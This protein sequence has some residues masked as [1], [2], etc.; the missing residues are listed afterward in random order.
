MFVGM[1][2]LVASAPQMKDPGKTF[3]R[4][5]FLSTVVL[6][7]VYC[8]VAYVAV[9][10]VPLGQYGESLLNLAAAELLGKIGSIL[11]AIAGM[12]AC[13]S[14]VGTAMMVQSSILGGM[15]RDGY[16]PKTLLKVHWRFGT[17]HIA[18]IAS[19][20]FVLGFSVVGGVEFLGYAASFGSLLVFALVNLSVIKLRKKEPHLKRPFKTP[21]YPITPLAGIVMSLLLLL[22]PI[23]LGDVNAGSALVSSLGLVGLALIAYHLRMVGRYRLRVALGA[24]SIS[25]GSSLALLTPILD[26]RFPLYILLSISAI[27]ILAGI[28]NI[29]TPVR[30]LF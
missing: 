16:L 13:V 28:L 25:M 3:P 21:L 12:V 18:I 26:L 19:S 6:T 1:R 27:S 29:I 15:S 20:I 8:A 24:I 10:A 23:F 17:R 7:I 5:L 9:M 2:A 22:F 4:A 30:K 11:F 14:S